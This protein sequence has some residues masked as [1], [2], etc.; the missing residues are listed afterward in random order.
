MPHGC[1]IAAC[2]N[3]EYSVQSIIV[4]SINRA[5]NHVIRFIDQIS[6]ALACLSLTQSIIILLEYS[7]L[8]GHNNYKW[9]LYY[10]VCTT[11]VLEYSSLEYWVSVNNVPR[12]TYSEC[13]VWW[14]VS[15][16]LTHSLRVRTSTSESPKRGTFNRFPDRSRAETWVWKN[17][18]SHAC[19]WH[20][21]TVRVPGI[22]VLIHFMHNSKDSRVRTSPK[23]GTF[24]RFPDRSRAET[25]AVFVLAT[26]STLS[27]PGVS[28][29][30]WSMESTKSRIFV[31]KFRIFHPQI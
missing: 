12:V 21:Y 7:T 1:T 9:V 4:Y 13:T 2:C 23:R 5:T 18:R 20:N 27:G 19:C 25:W 26:V 3:A 11:P 8:R 14:T 22:G 30:L 17:N 6:D 24:T 16:L 10:S 29:S 31:P 15:D 28:I